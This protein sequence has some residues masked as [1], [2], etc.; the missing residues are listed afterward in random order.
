MKRSKLSP[1]RHR[2]HN[3]FLLVLFLA[4]VLLFIILGQH[5]GFHI[6]LRQQLPPPDDAPSC[7]QQ[8]IERFLTAPVGNPPQEVIRYQQLL[9]EEEEDNVSSSYYF[10]PEQ[11]CDRFSSL[12]DADCQ[13]LC[14]PDGGLTG[15]GNGRCPDSFSKS[16][17]SLIIW[18]DQRSLRDKRSFW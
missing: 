18:E 12:Y 4:L 2:V 17:G 3:V 9:E 8:M 11:C 7:I 10:V 6:I 13:V 14:A 5:K 16:H 15:R 1:P